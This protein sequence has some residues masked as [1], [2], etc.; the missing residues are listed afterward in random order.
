[1]IPEELFDEDQEDTDYDDDEDVSPSLTYELDTGQPIDDIDAM[2]Q[3]VKKILT[4]EYDSS[5]YYLE[6]YGVILEDLIGESSNIVEGVLPDRITEALL[7]DD[8]I[9]G[10]SGFEMTTEGDTLICSFTVSTIFG[11]IEEA[12]DVVVG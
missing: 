4:T 2:V 12:I 6:D 11:D 3:A 9:D 5:P 1:M 8:R 10:I 7:V